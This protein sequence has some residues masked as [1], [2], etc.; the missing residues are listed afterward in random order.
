MIKANDIPNL[1]TL[2]RVLLT[3]PVVWALISHRF[4]LALWLFV[5]AG[6]SDAIDGWLAKQFHWQ[7]WLGSMLDPLADKL[8]LVSS[9][10][11]LAWLG[12]VP[13][14]LV[15][16]VFLRDLIIV[17]GALYWHFHIDS[18]TAEPTVVSKINTFVQIVLVVTVVAQAA[19]FGWL[20]E[21]VQALIWITLATTLLSGA[22]YVWEWSRRARETVRQSSNPSE[23]N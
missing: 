19:S 10:L 18:L 17:A 21:S 4:D 2:G 3:L 1:I 20:R 13:V 15:A 9:F 5:V 14:W 8:L 12:L 11:S 6:L 16:V 23:K 7:S 22:D